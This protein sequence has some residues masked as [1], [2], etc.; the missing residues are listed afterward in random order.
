[1]SLIQKLR[2]LACGVSFSFDATNVCNRCKKADNQFCFKCHNYN[3]RFMPLA[4]CY[5]GN[6]HDNYLRFSILYALL[7]L[8]SLSVYVGGSF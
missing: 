7:G 6:K 4:N 5:N 8:T 3:H 2:C 1:M